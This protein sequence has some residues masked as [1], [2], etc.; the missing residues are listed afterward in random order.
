M[1]TGKMVGNWVFAC[2][3][4]AQLHCVARAAAPIWP[5]GTP[6]KPHCQAMP[7]PH[8]LKKRHRI[9]HNTCAQLLDAGY[10]HMLGVFVSGMALY[11]S[12]A[13]PGPRDELSKYTHCKVHHTSSARQSPGS[14]PTLLP[15][16]P[17]I[18]INRVTAIDSWAVHGTPRS[19]GHERGHERM[20]L[21]C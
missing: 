16:T 17:S 21:R 14:L 13:T 9:T 20:L 10:A 18:T 11:S 1:G 7:Q 8:P 15:G 2:S 5:L 3:A 4:K 6:S 19:P 12:T